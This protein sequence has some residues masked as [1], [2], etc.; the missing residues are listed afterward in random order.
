V[1]ALNCQQE[2]MARDSRGS[3]T[4]PLAGTCCRNR[5]PAIGRK[6]DETYSDNWPRAVRIHA[7]AD[8]VRLGATGHGSA[9]GTGRHSDSGQGRSWTRP[10][11]YGPRRARPPLRLGPRSRAS[12]WLAPSSLDTS[13]QRNSRLPYHCPGER[14]FPTMIGRACQRDR[15]MSH[16]N[17]AM[18]SPGPSRPRSGSD[19]SDSWPRAFA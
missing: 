19:R 12:L 5:N 11:P 9:P 15:S 14:E 18:I 7:G 8:R 13:F 17:A 16:A 2:K 6:R 1:T 4:N 3:G 10:R